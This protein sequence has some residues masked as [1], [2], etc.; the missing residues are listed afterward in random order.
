M[1]YLVSAQ[2]SE[3][4]LLEEL[5][6]RFPDRTHQLVAPG[7]VSS[8]LALY[9][10]PRP[11]LAFARQ[12][13]PDATERRAESI[14]AWAELLW[15]TVSRLP[16]QQPW[17]LHV[18]PHYGARHAG[19]S[20]CQLI[21]QALVELLRRKRRGLLRTLQLEPVP[22][23]PTDS[24]VQ[25]LLLGPERGLLSVAPAPWPWQLRQLLSPFPKGQVAVPR[26][27]APPSRAYA[28]L[29]EAELRLGCRIG[30]GELCVD[31]GA[32]PGSWT[33]VAVRRGAR[34]IAV[35][36][37]PLRPDLMRHPRVEFH[38]GNAFT[39]RPS[40]PVDWLL[41]DVIAA[42]SRTIALLLDWVHHRLA[43]RFVVT[44]KFKGHSDY[45]L[46]EPLKQ[47]L[48]A[49]CAEFWLKR[50]CSNKNEVCAFGVVWSEA[51]LAAPG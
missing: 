34:V 48:A 3:Q 42:P 10:A 32:A 24:L 12:C 1:H 46:L 37:A 22:F 51:T 25:L 43:R 4:F 28:K 15:A 6:R 33:Y 27:K 38:R 44:I 11:V 26:N 7:L 35:D 30:P 8:D 39:F 40:Q 16:D 36:R 13:L 21:R 49:A 14:R 2:A 29:I 17:R 31:L 18:V 47:Q 50:L 5:Q 23:A 9:T 20:R 19:Q 41:C 45:G